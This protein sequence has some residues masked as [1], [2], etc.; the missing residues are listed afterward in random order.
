M[1]ALKGDF[2]KPRPSLIVQSDNY[3]GHTSVTIATM[4][5][6]LDPLRDVRIIIHPTPENGL[7]VPTQVL[8][9]RVQT[10]RDIDVREVIGR[11][12]QDQMAA[13]DRALALFLGLA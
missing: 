8:C 4:T 7:R 6:N 12:R 5:S 2:G 13:V 9:D 10:I 3:A 11:L 1:V